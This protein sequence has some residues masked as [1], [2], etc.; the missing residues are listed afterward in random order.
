MF[1]IFGLFVM[2]KPKTTWVDKHAHTAR[3]KMKTPY[4]FLVIVSYKYLIYFFS[5]CNARAERI[6]LVL[7]RAC[8]RSPAFGGEGEGR[9]TWKWVWAVP[10]PGF[11]VNGLIGLCSLG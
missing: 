6:G 3:K 10:K 8:P 2:K 1:I 11:F 4:H 9:P 5:R 7:T